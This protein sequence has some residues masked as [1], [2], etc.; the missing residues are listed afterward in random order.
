MRIVVFSDS[1]RDFFGLKKVVEAQPAAALFL[2]L[3]DHI[4][5]MEDI[6]NCYPEKAV[7]GVPGNCDYGSD[8][9]LTRVIEEGGVRIAMAHGHTLGVKGSLEPLKK[10]TRE[11]D[12]QI[13]LFG[14]THVPVCSYEDGLYL[15][16][17]GSLGHPRDGRPSYG[18]IDITPNGI[19][20]NIIYL[21]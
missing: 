3:G 20:T 4:R 13:A 5:D 19:V 9:P 8:A 12:A 15:L 21:K 16:N 17:P 18:I 1:H 14:H 11:E 7:L 10:W 2:H 6:R